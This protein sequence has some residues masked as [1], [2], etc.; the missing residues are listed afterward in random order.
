MGLGQPLVQFAGAQVKKE[1]WGNVYIHSSVR[2]KHA[3]SG[4]YLL[5]SAPQNRYTINCLEWW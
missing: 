4:A 3:V 2:R 1:T 5:Y